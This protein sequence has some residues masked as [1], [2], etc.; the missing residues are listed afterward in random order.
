MEK[1]VKILKIQ[2]FSLQKTDR[3][4]HKVTD[5]QTDRRTNGRTVKGQTGKRDTPKSLF[6]ERHNRTH[7][8]KYH[9]QGY[10]F[11]YTIYIAI[12]LIGTKN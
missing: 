2:Y 12:N 9:H 8:K 5:G 6:R 4:S 10:I 11:N 3:L 1:I 7:K